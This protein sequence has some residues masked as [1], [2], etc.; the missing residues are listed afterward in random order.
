M[1]RENI[2]KIKMNIKKLEEKEKSTAILNMIHI[3]RML[4][5][6]DKDVRKRLQEEGF[7]D[8]EIEEAFKK[9]RGEDEEETKNEAQAS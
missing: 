5:K 3:M 1:K 6:E 7:T 2:D 8:D 9:E 4:N